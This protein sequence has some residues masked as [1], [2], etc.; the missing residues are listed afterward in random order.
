MRILARI[1]DSVNWSPRGVLLIN[2]FFGWELWNPGT[3]YSAFRL[4]TFW[5]SAKTYKDAFFSTWGKVHFLTLFRPIPDRI[6]DPRKVTFSHFLTFLADSRCFSRGKRSLFSKTYGYSGD[7]SNLVGF[8]EI[9]LFPTFP[10]ILGSRILWIPQKI[11]SRQK[12]FLTLTENSQWEKISRS[13]IYIFPYILL[14]R[15]FRISLQCRSTDYRM[16][17]PQQF[18]GNASEFYLELHLRISPHIQIPDLDMILKLWD[19]PPPNSRKNI[20]EILQEF[21]PSI[22]PPRTRRKI[23]SST[24]GKSPD[25]QHTSSGSFFQIWLLILSLPSDT[26]SRRLHF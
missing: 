12:I 6:W 9:A 10:Q 2:V 17:S 23:L 14:F 5:K 18:S 16:I 22:F 1:P 7:F 11:Y 19:L 8:P 4:A 15:E 20:S 21:S 26:V 25:E 13:P 24:D 3:P